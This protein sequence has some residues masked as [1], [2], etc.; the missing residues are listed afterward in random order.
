MDPRNPVIKKISKEL[1]ERHGNSK[2]FEISE[3]VERVID[4]EKGL[5]PNLDFYAS[6]TYYL[7][8]IPILLYT[9]IF[10]ASR[11]SGWAAHVMEQYSDNRLI[12]PRAE[13]IGERKREYIPIEDR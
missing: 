9:P 12:R 7:L 6:S 8:G 13:Y 5:H 11:V 4:K 10:V 3:I 1:G 2:W